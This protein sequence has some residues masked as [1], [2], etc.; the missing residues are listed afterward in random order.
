[1]PNS[2]APGPWSPRSSTGALVSCETHDQRINICGGNRTVE[3][4]GRNTVECGRDT[5]ECEQSTTLKPS[6]YQ[7]KSPVSRVPDENSTRNAL[8]INPGQP[9]THRNTTQMIR[10]TWR[11]PSP[12]RPS[13]SVIATGARN[14]ERRA[15]SSVSLLAGVLRPL[16][17]YLPQEQFRDMIRHAKFRRRTPEWR[18][19]PTQR[20]T[21]NMGQAPTESA[22]KPNPLLYH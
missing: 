19:H 16:Y 8:Q 5:V 6:N 14:A 2:I 9:E 13:N 15:G 18:N 4:G 7:R 17:L 22:R 12:K 20:P 11:T 1:M 10:N 21:I 3:C